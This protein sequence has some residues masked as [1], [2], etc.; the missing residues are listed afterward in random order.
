M[1]NRRVSGSI[2]ALSLVVLV[3]CTGNDG[4]SGTTGVSTGESA[5]QQDVTLDFWTYEE[6]RT[7]PYHGAL[8]DAFEA[9]HPNIHINFTYIPASSYNVKVTTAIA[10]GKEPDLILAFDLNLLIDGALLPLDDMIAQKGIDLSTYNQGIIQGPG[11]Y[12]CGWEGKTYCL[13]SNQA[14]WGIF[15]NK[16]LF[17]AAGVP[18]PTAWPPMS[19]EQFASD[20][21]A[22]TDEA[23]G[24][25][26]AAVPQFLPTELFVSP[27]GRKAEGYTN[28]P[29]AVH[30][31]DVLSGAVRDGCSP[32]ANVVDPW[33]G[34][35]DFFAT[36][37]LAMAVCDFDAAKRF[38]KAGINYGVT[39]PATPPGIEPF[40][41]VYGDN[42]GVMKTS[43]HPKEAE[44]FVAFLATEGQK[45]AYETEGSI[46]IDNTVAEEVNWADDTP[47]RHD[48]LEVLSHAR[49]P[50]FIP[51][52]GAVFGPLYDAWGFAIGGE[53]T[54]QLALDDAAGAIQENLDKA[55][56]TWD[57]QNP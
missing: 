51:N 54:A 1:V 50:I 57:Q 20:A 6:G 36:G 48:I 26:G 16:D 33:D 13:A 34:S 29:E 53:K 43:D 2:L 18:Y 12:S 9:E 5:G 24:V 23:A 49:P 30:E 19:V 14:G 37:A 55:W 10:A 44:E 47:G 56:A 41:D 4:T 28:S 22:L 27:D 11:D 3:A 25:W 42:T 40:F 31:F 32:S 46:P 45:I 8:V 7:S 15:Y 52:K 39:G 21:C 35:A 17:D 38:E